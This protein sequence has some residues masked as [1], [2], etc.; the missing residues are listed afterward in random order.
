M[1]HPPAWMIHHP[2]GSW[3]DTH[4]TLGPVR[5]EAGGGSQDA[6]T[7]HTVHGT[8]TTL[9]KMRSSLSADE[10]EKEDS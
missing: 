5:G 3:Q 8:R 7:A 2:S 1:A 10:N 6:H 4:G 9:N